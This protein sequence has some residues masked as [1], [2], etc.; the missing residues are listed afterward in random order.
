VARRYLAAG[1]AAGSTAIDVSARLNTDPVAARVW[2]DA[3]HALGLALASAVLLLDPARVV[4][5]G[6]LAESGA[7]LLD[8][9][10]GELAARLTWR[11]VP[12]LERSGLGLDA[13]TLGAAML[14][15]RM[16]S[17]TQSGK[18]GSPR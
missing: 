12:P 8:P 1:G 10:R 9:V 6:G 17:T 16:I 15:R 2:A 4:L 18:A 13:G 5:G 11:P 7:A 14:A 3:T